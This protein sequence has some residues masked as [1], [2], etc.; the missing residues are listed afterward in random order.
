MGN[1]MTNRMQPTDD[2]VLVLG[3]QWLPAADPERLGDLEAPAGRLQDQLHADS[4]QGQHIDER[5][6]AEE[7]NPAAE[8]VA[9]ARLSDPKDLGRLCLL[10]ASGLDQLLELD[11]EV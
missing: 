5:I 10:E 4:Q 2:R 7:I 6:C 8:E 9:D 1:R 3:A 11:H